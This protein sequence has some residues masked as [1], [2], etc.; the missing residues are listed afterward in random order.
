MYLKKYMELLKINNKSLMHNLENNKI[1][2]ELDNIV[3]RQIINTH[4]DRYQMC[5]ENI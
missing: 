2:V 1:Q 3:S 4:I 5:N